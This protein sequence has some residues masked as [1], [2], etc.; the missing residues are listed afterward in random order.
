VFNY[1][2]LF[3]VSTMTGAT[4]LAVEFE[5]PE[6]TRYIGREFQGPML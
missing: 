6:I 1:L 2:K 3:E 5:E 4:T